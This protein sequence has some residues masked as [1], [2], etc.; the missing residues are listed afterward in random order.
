MDE[1]KKQFIYSKLLPWYLDKLK[2]TSPEK[3][4]TGLAALKIFPYRT[5]SGVQY[6]SLSED[7]VHW[8]YIDSPEF[9][10]ESSKQSYRILA[11]ED[12]PEH[13]R[14]LLE[15]L[16]NIYYKDKLLRQFAKE[17]VVQDIV[18]QMSRETSLSDTWWNCATEVFFLWNKKN[19]GEQYR[20]AFHNIRTP[21]ILLEDDYCDQSHQ[22]ALF[23]L[24][25]FNDTRNSKGYREYIQSVPEEQVGNAIDL[26]KY[27]G[28]P[29]KFTDE[30]GNIRHELSKLFERIASNIIY[31]VT[32]SNGRG[33]NIA[34]L[35][36]YI[37]FHSLRDDIR[38]RE[39]CLRSYSNVIPIRNRKGQYVPI[40]SD[41]FYLSADNET[42]PVQYGKPFNELLVRKEEYPEDMIRTLKVHRIEDICEKDYKSYSFCGSRPSPFELYR[43][44]WNYTQSDDLVRKILPL[45]RNIDHINAKYAFSVLETANKEDLFNGE[46]LYVRASAEL[47]LENSNLINELSMAST[48]TFKA[49]PSQQSARLDT[50]EIKSYIV[51]KAGLQ[52]SYDIIRKFEGAPFW[53]KIHIADFPNAVLPDDKETDLY[54]VIYEKNKDDDSGLLL[55][56]SDEETYIRTIGKYI[57]RQYD[58][59]FTD[60]V[61]DWKKVYFDLAHGIQSFI[62]KPTKQFSYLDAEANLDDVATF[63]D[64][65][66]IWKNLRQEYDDVRRGK[67]PSILFTKEYLDA[68]Y[69]GHCQICGARIPHGENSSVYYTYRMIKQHQSALADMIPNLFCV[70]PSCHGNLQYSA[71]VRDLSSIFKKAKLYVSKYTEYEQEDYDDEQESAISELVKESSKQGFQREDVR[72]PV[73]CPV[74][75][76]GEQ[77]TMVFSWEH[78][79]RLAFVLTQVEEKPKGG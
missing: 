58:C 37:F 52:Q 48:C 34:E 42:Q 39:N 40:E 25:L 2:N 20:D 16:K 17:F 53:N 70:C 27:F 71:K 45:L 31:P 72:N 57:E 15:D 32:E 61:T 54:A 38:G 28:I 5:T 46:L 26:L 33:Y 1:N 60:L 12:F 59:E 43:W 67:R 47:L 11:V 36:S 8:Y 30:S 13:N 41:L 50:T 75:V 29:T 23:A 64:E 22:Q 9:A 3:I 24:Q 56:R 55:P 4:K 62:Q 18:N 63:G 51:Q 78:F 35:C 73:E 79:I 21:E 44:A 76:N 65:K 77:K 49:V 10:G 66:R 6:G 68:H 74:K 69:K 14:E 19:P 7:G